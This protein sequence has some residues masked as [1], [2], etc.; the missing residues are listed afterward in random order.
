MADAIGDRRRLGRACTYLTN[1]FF[2]SGDQAQGL[3]YG[4]R[5]LAIADALGDFPLQAEAK[6]RLGQVHHALGEYPR[7]IEMLSGPVDAL[8]GD[9][10]NARFGLPLDLLGR[11]PH[12]AGPRPQRAGP[13][14]RRVC[15]TPTRRC[16]SPR[17]PDTP[18]ASRWRS[19][20]SATFTCAR[21]SSSGP[22]RCSRGAPGS[23]APGASR[24]GS[25]ASRRRWGWRWRAR[26]G[27][28]SRCR[29]S[30]GRSPTISPW[31]IRRR[32]SPRW[33]KATGWPGD[34]IEAQR[35]ADL[36]LEIARQY[37]DRGYGGV[38]PPARRAS[39]WPRPRRPRRRPASRRPWRSRKSSRCVRSSRM[40]TW[41]WGDWR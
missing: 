9:L 36:A 32:S 2:I 22:S 11:L 8:T 5:A 28:P 10:L 21:A 24:C 27:S 26:D 13:V 34:R 33:P 38:D 19:G 29:C 37:R 30:S 41:A 7:A 6:L 17:P 15:S 16:T 40:R 25:R 20:A 4:R 23:P 14:R 31:R 1:A 12:V 18:T 39:S 3:Q 35:H